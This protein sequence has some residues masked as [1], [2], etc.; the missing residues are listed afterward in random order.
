MDIIRMM[1][2]IIIWGA[3]WFMVGSG[4][5]ILFFWLRDEFPSNE[6][7][8]IRAVKRERANKIRRERNELDNIYELIRQTVDNGESGVRT[9]ITYQH[10]I[11]RLIDKGYRVELLPMGYYEI[12]WKSGETSL[13][14]SLITT[15]RTLMKQ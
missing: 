5:T 15:L 9:H 11:S 12:T 4:V 3:M 14:C 8:A 1:I 7:S 6:I 2:W 13:P 10:T